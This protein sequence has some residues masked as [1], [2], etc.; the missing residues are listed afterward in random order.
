VLVNFIITHFTFIL[1][2]SEVFTRD[3]IKLMISLTDYIS[4]LSSR[5]ALEKQMLAR[6]KEPRSIPVGQE[7]LADEPGIKSFFNSLWDS[8]IQSNRVQLPASGFPADD[9]RSVEILYEAEKSLSS[10]VLDTESLSDLAVPSGELTCQMANYFTTQF[11][12]L[13]PDS[14]FIYVELVL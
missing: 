4:N 10:R 8:P 7:C 13:V 3:D 11:Q 12:H 6:S 14:M 9:P 2:F 5:V 1:S